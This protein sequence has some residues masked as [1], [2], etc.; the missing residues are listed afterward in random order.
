MSDLNYLRNLPVPFFSQRQNDYQWQQRYLDEQS[1]KKA[2]K[3]LY[4][5]IPNKL[6]V[7]MDCRTCNITSVMM[8]MKY[9]GLTGIE[10]TVNNVTF[11]T[12]STP[13][14]FLTKYF[15]HEYDSLFTVKPTYGV[16][17][18]ED[19]NNLKKIAS[20]IFGANCTYDNPDSKTISL[21]N[22]K[23][24]VAAGYPVCISIGMEKTNDTTYKREGHVVVVRGFTKIKSTEYIILNDPWGSIVDDEF[25]VYEMEGKSSLGSYYYGRDKDSRT[26]GDNVVVRLSDFK[27][28]LVQG[29]SDSAD[30]K[31]YFHNVMTIHAPLWNFPDGT[32]DFTTE[33]QQA[34]IY[35][36]VRHLN[37]GYPLNKNN[38]WHTGVHLAIDGSIH[39]IGPGSLV[40]ARN[41]KVDANIYD[42]SF[43]LLEHKIKIETEIKSFFSLYMHLGYLDLKEIARNY[44]TKGERT[45]YAWLNQ[46]LNKML[47]YNVVVPNHDS[48]TQE[49]GQINDSYKSIKLYRVSV[50]DDGTLT[51]ENTVASKYLGRRCLIMPLPIKNQKI[52]PK[53]LDPHQYNDEDFKLEMQTATTYHYN[54]F[55]Y[56][57]LDGELYAAQL[58]NATNTF[59]FE[60]SVIFYKQLLNTAR[61]LFDLA[62]GNVVTFSNGDDYIKGAISQKL[63][64]SLKK[65]EEELN[66]SLQNRFTS[67]SNKN[68]LQL[69]MGNPFLDII[70]LCSFVSRTCCNNNELKA[71]QGLYEQY[72]ASYL[73]TYKN[74][75]DDFLKKLEYKNKC[76]KENTAR[77]DAVKNAKN[78]R[79]HLQETCVGI[80]NRI[81]K[82]Q[83][84]KITIPT[85]LSSTE[86]KRN[87]KEIVEL[88]IDEINKIDLSYSNKMIIYETLIIWLEKIPADYIE[89]YIYFESTDSCIEECKAHITGINGLVESLKQIYNGTFTYFLENQIEI[90]KDEIIGKCG[91]Y[92]TL[93]YQKNGKKVVSIEPQIHFEIFSEERNI[94]GLEHE[95]VDTDADILYNPKQ[96]IGDVRD[97]LQEEAERY[98]KGL[99]YLSDNMLTME[100]LDSLY[101]AS[102]NTF[103]NKVALNIKSQWCEKEHKIKYK[104]Y[105]KKYQ[106]VME[107]DNVDKLRK[108]HRIIEYDEYYEKMIKP[109]MWFDSAIFGKKQFKNDIAWFYHPLHFL[110]R[111]D[112]MARGEPAPTVSMEERIATLGSMDA[113]EQMA[114]FKDIVHDS[115]LTDRERGT[116]AASLRQQRDNFKLEELFKQDEDFMNEE[117]RDFLNLNDDGTMEYNMDEIMAEI[118][119][120]D[121][122]WEE[123]SFANSLFHQST[124]EFGK[125]NK[126]YVHADGREVVFTESGA[127][128]NDYPDKGTYNYVKGRLGG[129]WSANVGHWQYDVHPYNKLMLR[130]WWRGLWG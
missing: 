16:D 21:K 33:T 51:R 32:K 60:Y 129:S 38:V 76:M 97:I 106:V 35:G 20:D 89:K 68:I 66:G 91:K 55:I 42:K 85:D 99:G 17:C 39:S 93:T 3:K 11:T 40:A 52:H 90:G 64:D 72:M 88:F 63:S 13:K 7:S 127:T 30:E 96:C 128:I 41:S 10:R 50:S 81:E 34:A 54:N 58:W 1:A 19:W 46:L 95:I 83:N 114:L 2:G 70:D 100:E 124:A 84:I 107:S 79:I 73:K 25:N 24:E 6:P 44:F 5:I 119:R 118:K 22:V 87:G 74:E 36:R 67:I 120:G 62:E 110:E 71:I 123:M 37:G 117:L 80:L 92:E 98:G 12:P 75:L 26:N 103:L 49:M 94:L 27:G 122:Q 104:F 112:A 113:R 14:E 121:S 77:D 109:F 65:K 48:D 125:W 18:L 78:W 23:D 28:K 126:K 45:Q 111:L 82:M 102:S 86:T 105:K 15:N 31:T 69:N 53:L 59:Q 47:C 29:T 61:Q 130:R 101:K 43:I 4:D 116:L 56:F 8:V 9:L 115:R 108:R 57:F